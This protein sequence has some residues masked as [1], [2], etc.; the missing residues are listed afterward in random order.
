[1]V[2]PIVQVSLKDFE[3]RKQEVAAELWKAAT[4][5]GMLYGICL[6]THVLRR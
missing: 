4:E 3:T 5:I 1:M 2:R 6:L